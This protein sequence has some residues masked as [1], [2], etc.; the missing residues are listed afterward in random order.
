MTVYQTQLLPL[1]DQHFDEEELRTL[2]FNLG[3]QYDNLGGRGKAAQAR[4]LLARLDREQRLSDLIALAREQRPTVNWPD[5]PPPPDLTTA[6]ARQ[7]V[8]RR[9]FERA[10]IFLFPHVWSRDER[11]SLLTEAF[12]PAHFWVL[13]K[14]NV[15]G[16]AGTFLPNCWRVLHQGT[17]DGSLNTRLLR[18]VRTYYGDDKQ[19][20]IDSLITAWQQF[21]VAQQATMQVPAMT[22]QPVTETAGQPT[23]FL[24]YA[25]RDTA[26]AQ[27]LAAALAQYGHAC[28][29]ERAPK[30]DNNA[31]LAAI[32]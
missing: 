15:D 5:P 20:E 2:C 29:L 27:R 7:E 31:W 24:S 32:T 4:E 13:K 8:A 16:D 17:P 25:D 11:K 1:L 21:C 22:R 28:R 14:I 19:Q 12:Y 10:E 23:L 6:H 30:T 18:T 3:I 26:V 9:L